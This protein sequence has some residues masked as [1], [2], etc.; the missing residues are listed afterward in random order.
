MP[1][2]DTDLAF[3]KLVE[4][5]ISNKSNIWTSSKVH[6]N[7]L[8]HGG[9][10]C[11]KAVFAKLQKH[12]DE[13]WLFSLLSSLLVFCDTVPS[14]FKLVDDN[15]DD[16]MIQNI[17]KAIRRE[18]KNLVHD[19]NKYTIR[20][21]KQTGINSVSATLTSL[22]ENMSDNPWFKLPSIVIGNIIT[23]TVTNQPTPL[24]IG[25]GVT[26]GKKSLVQ[27]FHLLLK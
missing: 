9:K 19:K 16:G 27:Q 18:C 5:I 23:S 26:L 4:D 2:S 1:P 15:D 11:R 20:I 7:Y 13:N 25:L 3:D 24:Q 14:V 22:L 10:G 17:C 21:D 8:L 6:E 12:F